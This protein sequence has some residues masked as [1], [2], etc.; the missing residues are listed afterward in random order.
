[1]LI[2]CSARR[3]KCCQT[4]ENLIV[5][6][7]HTSLSPLNTAFVLTWNYV[8]NCRQIISFTSFPPLIHLRNKIRLY[9]MHYLFYCTQFNFIKWA[10][11]E[12]PSL[13]NVLPNQNYNHKWLS[14]FNSIRMGKLQLKNSNEYL[15]THSLIFRSIT[16]QSQLIKP[17]DS[18]DLFQI[19]VDSAENWTGNPEG[20]DDLCIRCWQRPAG[21]SV[22][23]GQL[24][25]SQWY[26]Y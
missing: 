7:L 13:E 17:D 26:C 4:R 24:I 25:S 3:W 8:G 14:T 19:I 15:R 22:R 16:N 2:T 11:K 20:R 23:M 10:C 12:F 6:Q 21:L 1:M 18:F 9:F 5:L